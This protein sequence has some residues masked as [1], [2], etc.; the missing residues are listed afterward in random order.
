M[1]QPI[2]DTYHWDANI[3]ANKLSSTPASGGVAATDGTG[4]EYFLDG[5]LTAL[6]L[7]ASGDVNVVSIRLASHDS[8]NS[9]SLGLNSLYPAT[10]GLRI[11]PRLQ[12]TYQDYTDSGDK[13]TTVGAGLR[14]EYYWDQLYSVEFDSGIDWTN[15]QVWFGNQKYQSY[16]FN[17]GYRIDF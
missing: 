7:Y 15:R 4:V 5:R 6:N 1:S 10:A 11:N 2:N 12:L 9:I 17:L 8:G 14:L 16:Y 13:E 3:S